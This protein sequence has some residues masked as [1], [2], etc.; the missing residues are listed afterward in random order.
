MR[1]YE[2]QVETVS[3]LAE[4]LVGLR[5]DA[6]KQLWTLVKIRKARECSVCRG[7]IDKGSEAFRPL[8]NGNNRYH[9]IHPECIPK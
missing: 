9:R 3:V 8:T 5:T 4:G 7:K 6:G 1:K 2:Y